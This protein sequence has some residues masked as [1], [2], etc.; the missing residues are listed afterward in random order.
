MTDL[1][2]DKAADWDTRP[3]P[4]QISEGVFAAIARSV[5]LDPSLVVMDFGA[6]TGLIAGR[7]AR[8]VGAVLAVDVS[9]SMLE[10]LAKK[11]ELANKTE[12]FCQNI[13]E[14]P[15]GR[16][17]DLIVSAMAMHHVQN[18]DALARALFA[19]CK[20]GGGVALADLDTEDGSFHPPGMEGVFHHGFDRASLGATLAAA[21][22]T[23]VRFETACQVDKEPRRYSVFLVTAQ[24][25]AR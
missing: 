1:F 23:D 25:P 22:F 24:R 17:V 6:G 21:G 16:A 3:A 5:R 15:L 4:A 11:P 13:L 18:T 12:V 2:Q 7:I 19:H 8:S 20:P 14:A 9:P 10:Q